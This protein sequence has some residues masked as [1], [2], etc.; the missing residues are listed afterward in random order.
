MI[1][2]PDG[3]LLSRCNQSKVDW[4]LSLGK[5]ELVSNDP[6]T[7]RLL[8]EPSGR[9]CVGDPFVLAGK[10]N[11]C[12]VC[13]TDEDLGRH[14]IVPSCFTRWMSIQ[15]KLDSGLKD[16]Q[17]LC[18]TCHMKYETIANLKK[19]EMAKA[20]GIHPCGLTYDQYADIVA[21]KKAASAL[22]KPRVPEERRRQFRE[23]LDQYFGRPHTPEDLAYILKWH[24]HDHKDF[25]LPWQTIAESVTNYDDFAAEW[26]Q[27]FVSTM[28]PRFLPECWS[29]D[30]KMGHVWV[31]RKV[32]ERHQ[33]SRA[34]RTSTS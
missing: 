21:V 28:Q 1:L 9:E 3:V 34:S 19:W 8:F 14:H 20:V 13:G 15:V 32:R 29:V 22:L 6:V 10:P 27:H 23:T 26:R 11:L 24:V 12:I 2:A 31:P 33:K 5:A 17:A 30:R 16:C 18:Y 7:I 25:K 4:Y